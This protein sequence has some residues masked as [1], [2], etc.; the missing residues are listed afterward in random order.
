M[1]ISSEK[2]ASDAHAK[3]M[4]RAMEDAVQAKSI[5]QKITKSPVFTQF[6]PLKTAAENIAETLYFGEKNNFS[7]AQAA[8]LLEDATQLVVQVHALEELMPIQEALEDYLAT[9]LVLPEC[10]GNFRSSSPAP[11]D[12]S[13]TSSATTRTSKAVQDYVKEA[14]RQAIA[15][16]R[17]AYLEKMA[18]SYREIK[19]R[20]S[21]DGKSTTSSDSAKSAEQPKSAPVSKQSSSRTGSTLSDQSLSEIFESTGLNINK[22]AAL[23]GKA[24]QKMSL[25]DVRSN[26]N[27]TEK[28]RDSFSTVMPTSDTPFDVLISKSYF[29]EVTRKLF[30]ELSKCDASAENLL[31]QE[32][33]ES[34]LADALFKDFAD[35]TNDAFGSNEPS[36]H[37]YRT[38]ESKAFMDLVEQRV[39]ERAIRLVR[40]GVS[41]PAIRSEGH[42]DNEAFELLNNCEPPFGGFYEELRFAVDGRYSDEQIRYALGQSIR[43]YIKFASVSDDCPL[44]PRLKN[45]FLVHTLLCLKQG[46]TPGLVSIGKF[47][48]WDG[49]DV[50]KKNNVLKEDGGFT[51]RHA[52]KAVSHLLLNPVKHVAGAATVVDRTHL[53]PQIHSKSFFGIRSGQTF[54]LQTLESAMGGINQP[55]LDK[56]LGASSG[57]GTPAER[58]KNAA[59]DIEAKRLD[60]GTLK[61]EQHYFVTYTLKQPE[62][63]NIILDQANDVVNAVSAGDKSKPQL[64]VLNALFK[65]QI[66][67]SAIDPDFYDKCVSDANRSSNNP[68]TFKGHPAGGSYL[69]DN[70]NLVRKSDMDQ[71]VLDG[72]EDVYSDKPLSNLGAHGGAVKGHDNRAFVF[73]KVQQQA[74]WSCLIDRLAK[75]DP[76]TGSGSLDLTVL[77]YTRAGATNADLIQAGKLVMAAVPSAT[78]RRH[79]P[80]LIDFMNNLNRNPEEPVTSVNQREMNIRLGRMLEDACIATGKALPALLPS[81]KI[82]IQ[83]LTNVLNQIKIKA[84]I[85]DNKMQQARAAENELNIRREP[86]QIL[87]ESI[88]NL[89]ELIGEQNASVKKIEQDRDMLVAY[90]DTQLNLPFFERLQL[91]LAINSK[92]SELVGENN[93][94]KD[95]IRNLR[96]LQQQLSDVQNEVKTSQENASAARALADNAIKD[97]N[98]LITQCQWEASKIS[99]FPNAWIYA[100]L[101]PILSSKELTDEFTNFV[102]GPQPS[103]YPRTLL[104]NKITRLSEVFT[105]PEI[106]TSRAVVGLMK[107]VVNEFFR[108]NRGQ[109]LSGVLKPLDERVKQNVSPAD[110]L[111]WLRS[112]WG[113]AVC[114]MKKEVFVTKVYALAAH[115]SNESSRILSRY[116]IG[117]LYDDIK[118]RIDS[119]PILGN[120]W[121]DKFLVDKQ[122]ELLIA[123][124]KSD[125]ALLTKDVRNTIKK[126]EQGGNPQ[127]EGEFAHAFLTAL[128]LPVIIHSRDAAVPDLYLPSRFNA[129]EHGHPDTWPTLYHH[130]DDKSGHWQFY[131]PVSMK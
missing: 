2:L 31:S 55:L 107:E 69:L 15:S 109:S 128:G 4:E 56:V 74:L 100:L 101:S 65:G 78:V 16:L 42:V 48:V 79:A 121:S 85:V 34:L 52:S 86:V 30:R 26:G 3:A 66:V 58:L 39:N 40:Q 87:E 54:R 32:T 123:I 13:A 37:R 114:S 81:D 68:A 72:W 53:I 126:I 35:F 73:Y 70:E 23:A 125:P 89:T 19:E 14:S 130:G 20:S 93:S 43:Q 124:V 27:F 76:G 18:A 94:L 71:K 29:G 110:N 118:N 51:S 21:S 131:K 33:K 120:I 105:G 119:S 45:E 24:A 96:Q 41:H 75:I 11:S 83:V 10:D 129:N 82:Q 38:D 104:V 99:D 8:S 12:S 112:A 5:Y 127:A 116:E 95:N 46:P 90:R 122:K 50:L 61:G 92:N 108:F 98:P 115:Y 49:I 28:L 91:R 47:T 84:E 36:L 102:A 64:E 117:E 59:H 7:P 67:S 62:K 1:G 111:C 44:K 6:E 113:A 17:P 25:S 97:L 63:Q 88:K 9:Q 77:G 22:F 106:K 80:G 103:D 60:L 57:T